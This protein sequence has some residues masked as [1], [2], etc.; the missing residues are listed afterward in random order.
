MTGEKPIH[1]I[2]RHSL[3]RLTAEEEHLWSAVASTVEPLRHGRKIRSSNAT[4]TSKTAAAGAPSP[5]ARVPLP[6]PPAS[7]ARLPGKRPVSPGSIARRDLQA[8]A[9]G[10]APIEARIDL[11]G[12][13]QTEAHAALLRFLRRA[14]SS[15][16]KFA[17]VI[18]GKGGVAAHEGRGILRRNVPLW[19][20]LP[21]FHPCVLGFTPADIAH[22]G[23]G[24]LF[25]QLRRSRG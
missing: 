22:G 23:D 25:V 9:R 7:S 11:H 10:R 16:A 24:A 13:T 19:L 2:P 17:L 14:Q 5:T 21:Q 15:G 3:R 1:P 6:G 18:T 8:L 4:R 12:M 20:A